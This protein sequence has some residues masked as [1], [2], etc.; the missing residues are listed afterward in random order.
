MPFRLRHARPAGDH[1]TAKLLDRGRNRLETFQEN[2]VS[3]IRRFTDINVATD[4]P[5]FRQGPNRVRICAA[6]WAQRSRG[7]GR[8]RSRAA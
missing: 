8:S 6:D 1:A 5:E 4:V 3:I 7:A 2:D